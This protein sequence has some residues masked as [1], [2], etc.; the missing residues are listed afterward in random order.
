ML[1][2]NAPNS[3]VRVDAENWLRNLAAVLNLIAKAVSLNQADRL[4]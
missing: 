3:F 4:V 1:L 2:Y